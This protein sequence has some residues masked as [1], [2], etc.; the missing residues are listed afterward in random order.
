MYVSVLIKGIDSG[1][2]YGYT[3]SLGQ[4]SGLVPA[5]VGLVLQVL[6]Q[7]GSAVYSQ[8]IGPFTQNTNL[9]KITI[10]NTNSSIVTVEGKILDCNNAAV[11]V[12]YAL[13][14][15]DNILRYQ[16]VSP[17]GDFSSTFV[18]C[19]S[20]ASTCDILGVDSTTQQQGNVVTVPITYPITYAGNISACGNSS[21][22]FIDYNIDGT[23]YSLSISPGDSLVAF[24]SAG[25]TSL[26]TTYVAGSRQSNFINFNFSHNKTAGVFPLNGLSTNGFPSPTLIQPLN[27]NLNN[28]PK[29]IGEF[30]DGNFSGQFTDA[31]TNAVIHNITCS[32]RLRKYY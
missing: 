25:P 11:T 14:S 28:F 27:V 9:G 21:A 13:I 23:D 6:N 1:H 12:G 19:S 8:N 31:S 22:E 32:F 5:N 4:V 2:A 7:C 16:R 20:I 29:N 18:T 30:Y 3:D 10:G 17:T 24:T 26:F 15:F